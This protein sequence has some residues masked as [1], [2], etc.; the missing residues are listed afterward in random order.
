MSNRNNTRADGELETDASFM[1]AYGPLILR[2]ASDLHELDEIAD[3]DGGIVIEDFVPIYARF[4]SLQR[5]G[6]PFAPSFI[7]WME[8]INAAAIESDDDSD[9]DMADDLLDHDLDNRPAEAPAGAIRDPGAARVQARARPA[10]RHPAAPG[11]LDAIRS[12]LKERATL[13]PSKRGN[14]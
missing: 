6:A 9:H 5:A 4:K 13:D 1:A 14:R 3:Q 12:R 8:T 7:T 10:A 11:F 2:L